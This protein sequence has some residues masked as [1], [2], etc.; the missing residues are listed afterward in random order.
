[1]VPKKA[2]ILRVWSTALMK[3]ILSMK[4][5]YPIFSK[6]PVVLSIVWCFSVMPIVML[7]QLQRVPLCLLTVTG[8]P[9]G[10]YLET[11]RWECPGSL[12]TL[13]APLKEQSLLAS[14]KQGG[15]INAWGL[16]WK[17]YFKFKRSQRLQLITHMGTEAY[18]DSQILRCG[19]D[20]K[21]LS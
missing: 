12:V 21:S 20:S 4:C 6:S 18:K 15:E 5:F 13:G 10:G 16:Q 8:F 3:S 14:Q 2:Q 9:E 11:K 7:L 17:C 19:K 1:M